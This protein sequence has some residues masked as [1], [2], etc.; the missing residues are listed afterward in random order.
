MWS[1]RWRPSLVYRCRCWFGGGSGGGV[2]GGGWCIWS[3]GVH[4]TARGT[5]NRSYRVDNAS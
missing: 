2:D 4:Y 1:Y 5:M 3:N